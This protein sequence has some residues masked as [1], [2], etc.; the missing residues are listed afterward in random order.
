MD[1]SWWSWVLTTVGLTGFYIVGRKV[2]WGWFVNL[3][4]QALWFMYAIVTG[5]YG[6]FAASIVYAILFTKNAIQWTREHRQHVKNLDSQPADLGSNIEPLPSIVSA[7]VVDLSTYGYEAVDGL[8]KGRVTSS[9]GQ[10]FIS[11][12]AVLYDEWFAI[13]VAL[14]D[15][16]E[17]HSGLGIAIQTEE[18]FDPQGYLIKWKPQDIRVE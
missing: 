2:W 11:R 15:Y 4:C 13:K 14:I 3:G 16:A 6:F 5:Q 9:T 10:V 12:A 17:E 1:S 8:R 7:D 18:V